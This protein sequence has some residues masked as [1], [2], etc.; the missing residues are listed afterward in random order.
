MIKP[1]HNM[2][3]K[4]ILILGASGKVGQEVVKLAKENGYTITVV[5]RS[6]ESMSKFSDIN[7][8]EGSV[9]DE[10]T[11][12]RAI[13][14]QESVV[15]CLGIK[16]KSQSNPWSALAS[17][18]NFTESVAEK[19]IPILKKHGVKRM[20]MI[21]SAGVGD[22]WRKVSGG[23][24]FLINTSKVKYTLNDFY[25]SEQAFIKSG[26]DFLAVRPV[27]LV[28]EDKNQQPKLVEHFKMSSQISRQH[29]AK[30][31]MDAL[32][33]KGEFKNPAEMIGQ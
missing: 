28:D 4:N 18:E 10:P 31:M 15:S 32:E 5:V 20:V 6:K 29:V 9:L 12:E 33:R 7:C 24:R 22:S 30:W 17:P 27:G 16:R 26:I 21:S 25:K 11:L 23:M 14:G 19:A 13:I 2:K 8:I 1:K 3:N